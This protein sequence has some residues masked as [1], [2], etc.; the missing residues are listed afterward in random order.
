M[1]YILAVSGGVDSMALLDMV[2][3]DA[4]TLPLKIDKKDIIYGDDELMLGYKHLKNRSFQILAGFNF[5]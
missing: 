4:E 3:T 5:K 1:H 2:A